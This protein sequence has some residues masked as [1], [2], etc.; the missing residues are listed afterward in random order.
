MFT[1]RAGLS[2]RKAR[3]PQAKREPSLA[4]K[5]SNTFQ[6]EVG[7]LGKMPVWGKNTKAEIEKLLAEGVTPDELAQALVLAFANW[8][9][10][11]IGIDKALPAVLAYRK[12][13]AAPVRIFSPPAQASKVDP[14]TF[15]TSWLD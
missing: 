14:D 11:V 12:A 13:H 8:S 7:K 6:A 4:T 9:A 2:T 3:E 10:P 1:G 15:D 5:L